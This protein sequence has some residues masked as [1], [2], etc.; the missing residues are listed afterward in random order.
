MKGQTEI[1]VFVLIFIIGVA[2]FLS[3]VV[4]SQGLF[5]R[6]SDMAKL[7]S[8]EAFMRNLDNTI[9][10]V[11]KF[12]G[13]DS[14]EYNIDATIELVGTN[15]VEIRCPMSVEIPDEW[16]NIETNE[17]SEIRE[18]KDGTI[19]RL[20]L[21]YPDNYPERQYS[22]HLFTDGAKIAT[23][24]RIIVEKAPSFKS[25]DITYNSIKLTFE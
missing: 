11:M 2:L 4:W 9:Q 10:N 16:I 14:V 20:A 24:Q 22:I 15:A 25:G 5:T 1:I 8:A 6:N 12:G 23:P 19:L 3:S 18:K 21:V 13:K 7:N 17:N